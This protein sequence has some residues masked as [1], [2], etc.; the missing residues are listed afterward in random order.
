MADGGEEPVD[1]KAE[2]EESCKPKCVKQLLQYQAC[3]ERVEKDETGEKHATG[4]YFDY[5]ACVDKCTAPKLFGKL[6]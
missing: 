1:P 4:Q 3:V 6:R 5:W 2:I